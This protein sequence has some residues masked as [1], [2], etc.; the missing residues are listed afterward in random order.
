MGDLRAEEHEQEEERHHRVELADA[1]SDIHGVHFGETA[2]GKSAAIF[3]TEPTGSASASCLFPVGP[4]QSRLAASRDGF[5]NCWR[6]DLLPQKEHAASRAAWAISSQ[7]LGLCCSR[8]TPAPTGGRGV[9]V[10]PYEREFLHPGLLVPL[11]PIRGFS[12]LVRRYLLGL[13]APAYARAYRTTVIWA[14][15]E[16]VLAVVSLALPPPWQRA[17]VMGSAVLG[18]YV[19]LRALALV[20]FEHRQRTFESD[21]IAVQ[22]EALRRHAFDVVRFTVHDISSVPYLR[23]AYDLTRPADVRDLFRRQA[24]EGTAQRLSRATVEFS[25]LADRGTFAIAEVHRDLAELTFLPG[26]AGAGGA[27]IRFPGAYYVGRPGQHP[28]QRTYW[29]LAGDVM[30]SVSEPAYDSGPAEAPGLGSAR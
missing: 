30:I 1:G 21:W 3:S 7:W 5:R 28:A 22:T 29:T 23:H 10:V 14:A 27:S 17:V 15:T 11:C 18:L 26:R 2:A 9:D 24:D 16:C 25:Y 4:R 20:V 6:V 8:T 13:R 19:I 12:G